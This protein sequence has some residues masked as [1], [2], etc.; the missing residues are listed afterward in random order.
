M[1]KT[2]MKTAC[3]ALA[4]TFAATA[5]TG[6]KNI[7]VNGTE[8]ALTVNGETMNMGAASFALRYQQAE[9]YSMLIAYGMAGSG[10]VWGNLISE[11]STYGQYFKD[12]T[13]DS[14]IKQ[15]LIRQ[16]AEDYSVTLTDEQTAAISA[17]AAAFM[18]ANTESV[19]VLGCTQADVENILSLQTYQNVM[20]DSIVADADTT[21]D[22]AE[23]ATSKILYARL[24]VAADTEAGETEVTDERKA[25]LKSEC[26]TVIEKF[27]L[28]DNQDMSMA[29][30][31]AQSVDTAFTVME[32]TYSN[33]ST[34]LDAA[35][36]EAAKTLSDGELYPEVVETDS[37]YYVVWMESVLDEEATETTR[38]S[39]VSE[40]QSEFYNNLLNTWK[41]EATIARSSAWNKLTV[42]DVDTYKLP[43][44]EPAESTSTSSESTSTSSES[45]ST[46]SE[47][48][49]EAEST[50]AVSETSEAASEEAG[51]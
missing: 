30:E 19:A 37:Y 21:V 27:G 12:Q 13:E 23:A 17:A 2:I 25:A 43:E 1:N 31:M 6:C 16:H 51:N 26:E 32:G 40:K 33:H 5:F 28:M 48:T 11:S 24:P 29:T 36:V 20:Y 49:S 44:A 22:E 4:V 38:S 46:S 10:S 3:A 42:N 35:V 15:M 45:V 9:T 47:S 41:E 14:L 7:K 34:S 18:E 50:S 39:I 8:N